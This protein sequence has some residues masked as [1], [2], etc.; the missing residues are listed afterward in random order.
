MRHRMPG[1]VQVGAVGLGTMPLSVEGRPDGRRAV[2]TV[3]AALDAGVTLLDTA[4]SHHLPGGTHGEGELPVARALASRPGRT[5]DVLV[6][7]KGGRGRTA[8]G[9]WTADGRPEHLRRAA[10]ASA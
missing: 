3:R 8:D 4:D 1:D 10:E 7:T 5:D 6:A 2:A 9:G